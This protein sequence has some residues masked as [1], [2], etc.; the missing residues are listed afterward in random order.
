LAALG[1]I[2]KPKGMAMIA[3]E[4]GLENESLYKALSLGA[5]SHFNAAL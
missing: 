5:K 4:S 1:D 2:A 3:K